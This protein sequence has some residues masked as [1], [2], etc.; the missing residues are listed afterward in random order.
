MVEHESLDEGGEQATGK[1]SSERQSR[2][3]K[4]NAVMTS[5]YTQWKRGSEQEQQQLDL[6]HLLGQAVGRYQAPVY[7]WLG[8]RGGRETSPIL[9]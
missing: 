2:E 3:A 6:G 5:G 1:R 9:S 4:E 8:R 7:G